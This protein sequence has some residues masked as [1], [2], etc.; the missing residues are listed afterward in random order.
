MSPG[1]LIDPVTED[2]PL[3]WLKLR[4][5]EPMVQA[6]RRDAFVSYPVSQRPVRALDRAPVPC[7][8]CGMAKQMCQ[9]NAANNE[10]VLA[11]NRVA[12]FPLAK[13]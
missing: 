10:C 7:T 1:G 6:V 8:T 5:A 2:P 3:S 13:M 11:I 9:A 4:R 12:A